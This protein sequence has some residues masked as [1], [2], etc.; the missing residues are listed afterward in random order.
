MKIAIFGTGGV[1]GYFG[2]RLAQAGENVIFIARGEHLK[3][4]QQNGL[5]ISSIHG[6]FVVHPAQATDSTESIGTVDLIILAIKAWQLDSS[7]EQIRPLIGENTAILPLLNGMEHI[8]ILVSAFGKEHVLGGLCRI[9]TFVEGAGHIRHMG[10][11]PI[12]SFGELDNTKTKRVEA[13]HKIFS[14]IENM[15]V[16]IP[17]DIHT[18][19]WEKFILISSTSGVGAVSRMPINQYRDIPEFRTMLI[20]AMHE[21][22][23]VARARSASIASDLVDG[24]MKRIDATPT[25]MLTSMQ[26][27]I[28]EGRPSELDNQIGA[29]I[30]IGKTVNIPTPIHEKIYAELLPL[31]QKARGIK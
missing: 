19:M 1:G 17:A 26:K 3:A 4:I 14:K 22:E 10:V 20:Q 11:Q 13:I 28:M 5:K 18:A 16:E 8:D 30:R 9:S 23:N 24:I 12:I 25:G 6:D 21:T 7:L 15:T 31:E 2:G 29:V 27:D